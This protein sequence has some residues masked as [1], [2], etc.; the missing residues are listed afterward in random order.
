MLL[1]QILHVQTGRSVFLSVALFIGGPVLYPGFLSKHILI[2]EQSK[3][4]NTLG[5]YVNRYSVNCDM[6]E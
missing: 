1:N 5:L 4:K 3:E 2:S 6:F